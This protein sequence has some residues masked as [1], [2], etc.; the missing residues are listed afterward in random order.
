MEQKEEEVEDSSCQLRLQWAAFKIFELTR[1][2]E[3]GAI[4]WGRLGG[5]GPGLGGRVGC[6]F[7]TS[8][9]PALLPPTWPFPSWPMPVRGRAVTNAVSAGRRAAG[10]VQHPLTGARCPACWN[11]ICGGMALFWRLVAGM[12][13]ASGVLA[14][15][16]HT[17]SSL[18]G[19]VEGGQGEGCG[20][21]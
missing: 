13:S 16:S 5:P 10:A 18:R 3:V 4:R 12:A 14:S 11:I 20:E 6:C 15:R 7:A 9:L 2:I 8:C 21:G 1:G 17:H 19:G